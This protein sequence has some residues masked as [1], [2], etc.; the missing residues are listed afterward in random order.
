[1]WRQA[2]FV[3]DDQVVNCLM[4]KADHKTQKWLY[5]QQVTI[6][7]LTRKKL[8]E[9]LRKRFRLTEIGQ[10]TQ[11]FF[12]RKQRVDEK[13]ADF[14]VEKLALLLEV[15]PKASEESKVEYLRQDLLP[16]VR[17]KVVA[18]KVS[19]TQD[20][21]SLLEDIDAIEIGEN[22]RQRS[23]DYQP[24]KQ[25]NNFTN[26]SGSSQGTSKTFKSN[27]QSFFNKG[28][29]K[30]NFIISN[31]SNPVRDNCEFCGKANHL[32]RFCWL[33]PDGLARKSIVQ[34]LEREKEEKNKQQSIQE[35]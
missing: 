28:E 22:S 13:A 12:S 27:K 7:N 31:K 24:K 15:D 21:I 34:I 25:V 20:F 9:L 35:N 5:H 14:A 33:N 4:E 29:K 10:L 16:S 3:T 32:S 23:K 1:M 30:V 11:R 26:S 8:Q 18:S 2:Y 19:S 6:K 17:E